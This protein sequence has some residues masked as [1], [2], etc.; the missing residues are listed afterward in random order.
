[1]SSSPVLLD[2]DDRDKF[3]VEISVPYSTE[4]RWSDTEI[5]VKLKGFLIEL[6]NEDNQ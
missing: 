4:M 5:G 1:M 3:I 2:K 6:V